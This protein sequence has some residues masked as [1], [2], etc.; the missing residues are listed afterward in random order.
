MLNKTRLLAKVL[1]P[2]ILAAS[3]LAAI[4]AKPISEIRFGVDASYPPF[5]SRT[6][7]GGFSGFNIDLGN[8][9]CAYLNAKCVWVESNFDGIIPGLQ[10]RKF[11]AILSSMVIT[12]KRAKQVAFTDKISQE[13][14][15][16]IAKENS[17]LLPT[18]ASLAGKTVGVEQGSTQE[19]YAKKIWAPGGVK[20]VS[21]L[22]QDLVYDDLISGRLDASFQSLLVGDIGFL[23]TERGKGFAFNGESVEDPVLLPSITAIGVRKNDNDLREALNEAIAALLADGTYKQISNKYFPANFDIYGER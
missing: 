2:V 20:V 6:P 21:Y 18:A 14:S 17:G 13:P 3:S 15:R 4:A 19:V 7:D 11:D 8:A 9:I 5:E 12:E 22:N 16:L 23:Q 1:L 10:A